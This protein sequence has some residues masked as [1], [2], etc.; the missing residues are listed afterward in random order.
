MQPS[1]AA[2]RAETRRVGTEHVDHVAA[3][4]AVAYREDPL[5]SWILSVDGGPDGDAA[6]RRWWRGFLTGLPPGSEIHATYEVDGVAVWR[7]LS[8]GV[9]R[10]YELVGLG[11]APRS[12]RHGVSRRV[13][14]P[15]ITR[16][17]RLGLVLVAHSAWPDASAVTSGPGSVAVRRWRPEPDG[18]PVVTWRRE[19]AA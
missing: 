2:R 13:R 16:A 18:P 9:E 4:L 12:R 1:E 8:G 19:P 15:M 6:R 7:P 10:G 5:L 3:T 17:D 11:V 14:E